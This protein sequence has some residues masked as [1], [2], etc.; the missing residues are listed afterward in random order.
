MFAAGIPRIESTPIK[1][2]LGRYAERQDVLSRCRVTGPP[3]SFGTES[4]N[5]TRWRKFSLTSQMRFDVLGQT[6]FSLATNTTH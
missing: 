2:P 1:G 4:A 5:V 3:T 6:L